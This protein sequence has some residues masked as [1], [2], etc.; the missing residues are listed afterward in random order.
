MSFNKQTETIKVLNLTFLG[1]DDWENPVY[2]DQNGK[3]WKDVEMKSTELADGEEVNKFDLCV[4]VGNQFDG[5]PDTCMGNLKKYQ[6]CKVN[7][8]FEEKPA[9]EQG[10]FKY[11]MLDRLRLDCSAHL[12]VSNRKIEDVKGHI[13][14][15]KKLWNSLLVKPE[16]LSYEEILNYEK[17]ML[18]AA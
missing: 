4:C 17:L 2:K 9:S 14:E 13:A 10:R 11:M 7:L 1:F 3:L 16:W 12:G 5:E 18:V 15:M 6:N 8:I